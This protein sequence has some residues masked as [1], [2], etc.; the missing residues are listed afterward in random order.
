M[1]ADGAGTSTEDLHSL[2]LVV[3]SPRTGSTL[4]CRDIASLGGLG[5]PR[6]WLRGF[7]SQVR[8]PG[9][10]EADVMAQLALGVQ[11]EAPGVGAVKL[12]AQQARPVA[13]A[14]TGER[15]SSPV[16]AVS[17]VITWAEKRFDRVLLVLLVRNTLDQAISRAVADATGIYHSTSKQY[18]QHGE[19]PLDGVDINDKVLGELPTVLRD[20]KT[21]RAV[22]HEHADRA[23]VLTYDDLVGDADA[24]S[25]RLVAHAR[26]QGFEPHR[27]VPRRRLTKVISTERAD[28]LRQGFLEY[29]GSEPGL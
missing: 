17:T 6:E 1:V 14:L 3:S 16:D 25:H 12:M 13:Q 10:A 18:R 8:S 2:T 4:L 15:S 20:R 21:L 27:E 22:A 28:R 29:F 26:A 11:D 19:R 9:V 23:L 7:D 24:T 5:S